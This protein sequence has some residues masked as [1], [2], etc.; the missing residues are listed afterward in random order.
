MSSKKPSSK[1]KKSKDKSV[2]T[3]EPKKKK[4]GVI[5]KIKS[6]AD[7][8]AKAVPSV[9]A[10]CPL[11]GKSKKKEEPEPEVVET[12]EPVVPVPWEL[13]IQVES[14]TQDWPKDLVRVELKAVGSGSGKTVPVTMYSPTGKVDPA[15]TG[16]G[17]Q[18]YEIEASVDKWIVESISPKTVNLN[19]GDRKRVDVRIRPM[20]WVKFHV[21]EQFPVGG[22]K[23]KTRVLTD[24]TLKVN[25]PDR[26]DEVLISATD[27]VEIELIEKD[28]KCEITE[29]KHA[30]LWEV[31]NINSSAS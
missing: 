29:M 22:G 27:P 24:V 6:L 31:V 4:K 17:P 25:Q 10:S 3:T 26:K 15:D 12:P 14:T 9:I 16:Q 18:T 11:I 5:G 19:D 2:D 30:E 28:G 21:L 13:W 8:F 7:Q 23:T 20:H 1:E